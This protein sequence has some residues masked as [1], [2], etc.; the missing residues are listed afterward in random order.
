[1]ELTFLSCELKDVY[2]DRLVLLSWK[3]EVK[4]NKGKKEGG[5][6]VRKKESERA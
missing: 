3:K 6:S 1:M 2:N 4:F 5:G